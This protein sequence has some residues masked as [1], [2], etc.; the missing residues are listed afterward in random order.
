MAAVSV[1]LLDRPPAQQ[2]AVVELPEVAAQPIAPD[3]FE[4]IADTDTLVVACSCSSSSDN[5]YS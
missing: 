4:I 2:P 5:P 3:D 1:A